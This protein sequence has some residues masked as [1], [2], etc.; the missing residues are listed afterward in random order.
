MSKQLLTFSNRTLY[1][2]AL[3]RVECV[4]IKEFACSHGAGTGNG[5]HKSPIECRVVK[6]LVDFV[7]YFGTAHKETSPFQSNHDHVSG[8]FHI[9]TV[10]SVLASF[11][12]KIA[13]LQSLPNNKFQ[14]KGENMVEMNLCVHWTR[15]NYYVSV[16]HG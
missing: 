16:A 13:A 14:I 9:Y 3:E 5:S 1:L 4:R 7:A 8:I 12:S 6:F 15:C 11:K 10:Q 2:S